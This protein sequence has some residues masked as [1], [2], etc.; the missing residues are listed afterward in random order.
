MELIE[1]NLGETIVVEQKTREFLVELLVEK[2]NE[3]GRVPTREDIQT[4]PKM[5]TIN[6]FVYTFSNFDKAVDEAIAEKNRREGKKP[7]ARVR[8]KY[9]P[10]Y[11]KFNS[12][13]ISQK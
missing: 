5:P 10:Y 1:N 9:I 6:N 11:K 4:D 7:V 2:I 8:E 3:L 12:S 13:P